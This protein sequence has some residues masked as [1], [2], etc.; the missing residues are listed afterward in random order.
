MA[1]YQTIKL[2]PNSLQILLNDESILVQL[3]YKEKVRYSLLSF[4]LTYFIILK[5]T[6]L[7]FL[8]KSG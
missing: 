7:N 5:I 6:N 1:S 4:S 8:A 2:S 3:V